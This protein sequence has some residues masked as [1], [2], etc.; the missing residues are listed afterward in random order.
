MRRRDFLIETAAATTALSVGPRLLRANDSPDGTSPAVLK[1]FIVSDAHFGW[2]HSQ[3]PAPDEQREMMRRIMARFPDL[4]LFID[5][6]DAHHGNAGDEARGH[7]TD[8]IAGGCGS[9]PF[10]Y[11]AGNHELIPAAGGDSEWRSNQLGSVCCRPYYSLDLKGIHFVSLPEMKR[12]V[13]VTRETMEWLALDLEVHKNRTVLILSHNHILGTTMPVVEPGYRGLANSKQV[14]SLLD[15]YSNVIGW[16]NGHNH[17]YE[18]MKRGNRLYV[19]NGRIGGFVPPTAWGKVGQGHLGGIYFEVASDRLAVRSYS[20]TAGKFL[21][22]LGDTHL[23]ATLRTHTTLDPDAPP[24]HC[25][26]AGGSRDGQRIPV[27]HHHATNRKP[28][29]LFITG[30]DEAS[31]NDDPDFELYQVR[32]LPALGLH[33]QLMNTSV[34]LHPH[35]KEAWEEN[36]VYEW[37]DPGIKLLARTRP[38]DVTRMSVPMIDHGKATCYRCPPG[39]K[40]RAVLDLETARGGQRLQLQFMVHDRKLRKLATIDGP[41]LKLQVGRHRRTVDVEVPDFP[42]SDCIYNNLTSDNV[43]HLMVLAEIR[44]LTVDLTLHRF[45][46]AFADADGPTRNPALVVDGKQYGHE[47]DLAPGNVVRVELPPR[48]GG[49]TVCEPRVKGNRR[50]TWLIRHPA[51]DWQVRNAPVAD[52]GDHLVIGPLR[53]TFSDRREIVIAPMTRTRQPLVHRIRNADEVR[54]YPLNR[55]N[56]QLAIAIIDAPGPCEI[57]IVSD[58]EPRKV[59]G[60][61]KWRHENSRLLIEADKGSTV[62]VDFS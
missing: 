23:S 24:T 59:I 25:Y 29:E 6:G 20:A 60:A 36:T 49:R 27:I 44:N 46:L 9:L 11:V 55:G 14:L 61:R 30:T 33:H 21:D 26:G 48:A 4:D 41:E 51:P 45:E 7:W 47:G 58:R 12:A 18:V 1:G 13:F 50:V 2:R 39:R 32:D 43:V 31:F 22:E 19:S 57:E 15:G 54:V 37:L 8:V 17:T 52:R 3:Q 38:E 34:Q 53:N 42:D 62:R 56:R 5:T 10:Y 28:A 40:Y 16:L 35:W